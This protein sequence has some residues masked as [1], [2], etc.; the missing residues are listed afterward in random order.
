ME[1]KL[2]EIFLDN[3]ENFLDTM[4]DD[5][6]NNG[7]I[8]S[9]QFKKEMKKYQKFRNMCEKELKKQIELACKENEAFSKKIEKS[10]EQY[11]ESLDCENAFYIKEHH[12]QRNERRNKI[13]NRCILEGKMKSE[14]RLEL[15]KVLLK[16]I[17]IRKRE[18]E[19]FMNLLN[20]NENLYEICISNRLN[21]SFFEMAEILGLETEE[22]EEK[23]LDYVESSNKDVE[24]LIEKFCK[25]IISET[26]VIVNT[27]IV[28]E[29]SNF[30][31]SYFFSVFKVSKIIVY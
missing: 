15:I 6:Q 3:A 8:L 22:D 24:E 11:K 18:E 13:F 29:K 28:I 14:K 25:N 1:E 16:D 31:V 5:S 19:K 23:M 27:N 12:K 10:L 4:Y 26:K 17:I 30:K 21:N 9:N 20:D 2:K 7:K